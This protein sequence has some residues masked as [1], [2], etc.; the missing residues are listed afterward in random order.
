MAAPVPPPGAPRPRNNPS[1][2][3][4]PN[5]TP[6][7]RGPP[8][9]LA[10]NLQN[11][12]LN[13]RPPM[14]SNPV[15]RPPPFGQSPPF[16]TSAPSPQFPGASPPFS[17]PGL[18]PPGAQVRPVVPPSGPPP[19]TLLPGRPTGPPPTGQPVPFGS[20]PSLPPANS[21]PSSMGSTPAAPFPGGFPPIRQVGPSPPSTVGVR[22]STFSSS[23]PSSTTTQVMPPSNVP[24]NLTSNG[25]PVFASGA[26]PGGPRLPPVGNAPQPAVGSA[27]IR[28]PPGSVV[29]PQPRSSVI[30]GSVMPPSSL[31][32]GTPSWPLQ[33]QQVAILQISTV[34]LSLNLCRHTH[35]HNS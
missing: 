31:P 35:T 3:P 2:P 22:P 1:P 19:S 30:P 17:R 6:N 18:P 9:S 28:T 8:D 4:P 12:N 16:P 32:Y 20:R 25:Q 7:F 11:L 21:V 14:V 33:P 27:T 29:Q 23:S 15:A 26:F 34:Y 10:D 5:Y 13:N 24:A